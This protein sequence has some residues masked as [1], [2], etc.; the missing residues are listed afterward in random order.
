MLAGNPGR[1][2]K[3]G[4]I[5]GIVGRRRANSVVACGRKLPASLP[6]N[7]D[8]T[9]R[10]LYLTISSLV[11]RQRYVF[12]VRIHSLH[13]MRCCKQRWKDIGLSRF[14][15][16]R[17]VWMGNCTPQFVRL[18]FWILL[19]RKFLVF[20]LSRISFRSGLT[21]CRRRLC[22][23]LIEVKH[24]TLL[25]LIKCLTFFQIWGRMLT[26]QTNAQMLAH[27]VG[28]LSMAAVKGWIVSPLSPYVEAP[29]PSTS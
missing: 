6:V 1:D 17:W 4:A 9:Q 27:D 22:M 25:A 26:C 11:C 29:T 10:V 16:A 8:G 14:W 12:S 24:S 21:S 5:W 18:P 13:G 23:E 15:Q 20:S 28:L 19:H 2:N 7:A 3:L